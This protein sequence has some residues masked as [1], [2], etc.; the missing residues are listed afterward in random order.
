[1]AEG[2][3]GIRKSFSDLFKGILQDYT[4]YIIRNN[5]QDFLLGTKNESGQ[6][7]GGLLSGFTNA[8]IGNP[9]PKATNSS[10]GG[11]DQPNVKVNIN[12]Q[13]GVQSQVSTSMGVGS[14]GQKE[15]QFMIDNGVQNALSSGAVDKTMALNYGTRRLPK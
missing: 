13:N 5:V 1:M 4:T 10:I 8:L 6:R 15:L 3:L 12:N 7:V 9:T 14:N 11:L 2:A